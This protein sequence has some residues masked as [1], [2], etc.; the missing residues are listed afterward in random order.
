MAAKM[1]TLRFPTKCHVCGVVIPTGAM[2]LYNHAEP[3]GRRAIHPDCAKQKDDSAKPSETRYEKA[4][5]TRH[6]AD[7]R[8]EW[9]KK[10]S[11][12]HVHYESIYA[13]TKR[14]ETYFRGPGAAK[15]R[16]TDRMTEALN[17]SPNSEWIGA[18]NNLGKGNVYEFT[19]HI[20]THGWAEG[21]K[22]IE[23]NLSNIG[24]VQRPVSMKRRRVRADQ[25]DELDIHAV[26]RGDLDHAWLRMGR[27]Q[28]TGTRF[29]TIGVSLSVNASQSGEQ[30]MWAAGAAMQF[31]DVLTEGGYSVRIIGIYAGKNCFNTS[32]IHPTQYITV[33]AKDYEDPVDM[34][35]L[36][37]S[38]ASAAFFR[39]Y[40]FCAFSDTEVSNVSYG[41]GQPAIAK[42][43]DLANIVASDELFVSCDV[44]KVN[45]KETAVEWI[46]KRVKEFGGTPDEETEA[47]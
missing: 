46:N 37:T 1:M 39:S 32:G 17:H 30:L 38:I 13:L 19:K 6:V 44:A 33:T 16:N 18:R 7:G 41:L 12:R 22:N 20:A 24:E 4:E 47:V 26:Y 21:V 28:G 27:R 3:R 2:A 35:R 15:H 34:N 11:D 42:K 23:K 40:V 10:T 43:Q 45:S 14:I 29:I 5:N 36:T 25:G 31:A 8:I 9:G